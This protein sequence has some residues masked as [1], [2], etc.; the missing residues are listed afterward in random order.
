SSSDSWHGCGRCGISPRQRLASC[1]QKSW[2]NTVNASGDPVKPSD[3]CVLN[4][5]T[6]TSSDNPL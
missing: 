3:A 4:K 5:S 2:T 1:R 6:S